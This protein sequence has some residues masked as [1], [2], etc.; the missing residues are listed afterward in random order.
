MAASRVARADHA[1]AEQRLGRLGGRGAVTRGRGERGA[2]GAD[3]LGRGLVHG[4]ARG[5]AEGGRLGARERVDE[6]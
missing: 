1:Q 2:E 5:D 6:P 3:H 4:E